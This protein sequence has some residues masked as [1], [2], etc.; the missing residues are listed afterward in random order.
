MTKSELEI[1]RFNMCRV[2]FLGFSGSLRRVSTNTALLRAAIRS[3]PEGV[4]LRLYE[5]LA[6]LPI[7]NPDLEEGPLPDSVAALR[8][9]VM[10]ADGL[11]FAVPEY[12]H[13][14]PGGLKN[15]LDWL[16]S[17]SEIPGKPVTFFHASPRSHF[18]RAA[19]E[20]VLRT[21]SVRLFEGASLT[22]PLL[23]RDSDAIDAVLGSDS[24]RAA[25]RDALA[26]FARLID[27][28]RPSGG[29]TDTEMQ[30]R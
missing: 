21:M 7:F 28:D 24:S 25:L 3:A 29:L 22:I 8:H 2:R 16:V 30:A 13:G 9:M 20:E 10:A 18:G 5:G 11:V 4:E 19:L 15:A 12:A 1:G 26:T 14:V 17:G 23:G 27:T 6:D